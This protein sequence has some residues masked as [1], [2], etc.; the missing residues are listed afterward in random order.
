MDELSA[1][2]VWPEVSW[3]DCPIDSR[4]YHIPWFWP[5][6]TSLHEDNIQCYDQS[7]LGWI[8]NFL[9]RPSSVDAAAK[10]ISSIPQKIS[11]DKVDLGSGLQDEENHLDLSLGTELNLLEDLCS[12]E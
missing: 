9:H 2:F 7:V 1:F 3:T 12:K 4:G 11:Q 5:N 8:T 10:A 6:D